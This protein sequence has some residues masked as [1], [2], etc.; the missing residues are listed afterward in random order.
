MAAAAVVVIGVPR[1]YL[2]HTHT[3]VYVCVSRVFSTISRRSQLVW[4]KIASKYAGE[5]LGVEEKKPNERTQQTCSGRNDYNPFV[6][7]AAAAAAPLSSA[8]T[9]LLTKDFYNL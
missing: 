1:I 3:Q 2:V 8:E 5:K 6:N 9:E 4:R 7:P